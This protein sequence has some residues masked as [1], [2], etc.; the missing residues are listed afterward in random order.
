MA[1]AVHTEKADDPER[2]AFRIARKLLDEKAPASG[3][4]IFIKPNIVNASGPPVTTDYRV[5]KGIVAALRESGYTDI[6]I[7][8]G[9]GTGSTLDNFNALGYGAVDAERMDLDALPSR[10]V[11]VPEAR[12]WTK[13]FLPEHLNNG[14][15]VSVPALKDHSMLGVTL[16]LKNLV[17][18]LPASHYSG[19]WTYKKS[20]IH[21]TDAHACVADLI[22][23]L[24]PDWSIVDGTVGMKESHIHGRPC[25]PPKNL[26]FGSC[27]P[28][29]ADKYGCSILGH[30]WT[31]IRYLK[32]IASFWGP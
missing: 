15:I 29:E 23:V 9:S 21:R 2:A 22:R 18:A 19:Y 7:T 24:R 3:Q 10:P 20:Q 12:I 32:L 13:I 6:L 4:T 30:D 16:S 31:T 26:V 14:F 1:A 28:L 27:D 5:V 17:G 25:S 8:E 11:T